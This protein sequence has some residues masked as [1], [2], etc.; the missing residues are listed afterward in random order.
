MLSCLLPEGNIY[1]C[2][3]WADLSV[4]TYLELPSRTSLPCRGRETDVG[5]TFTFPRVYQDTW[6]YSSSLL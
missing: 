4:K 3:Q 6:Y 5:V 2:Q 1:V